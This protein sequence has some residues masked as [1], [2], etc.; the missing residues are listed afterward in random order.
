MMIEGPILTAPVPRT[1]EERISLIYF[2]DY[3][4]CGIT[5]S[6]HDI[7]K[8]AQCVFSLSR[9]IPIPQP[10]PIIISES[11]SSNIFY[12]WRL[13]HLAD[14]RPVFPEKIERLRRSA[15]DTA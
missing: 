8:S 3:V 2:L 13:V 15:A 6:T 11:N 4:A 14:R 10:P 7:L 5:G 12:R 1:K 9:R